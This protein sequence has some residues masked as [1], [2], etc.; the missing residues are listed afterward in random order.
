MTFWDQ[1]LNVYKFRCH[2]KLI[3]YNVPYSKSLVEEVNK[4]MYTE[5]RFMDNFECPSCHF[6]LDGFQGYHALGNM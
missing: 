2:T 3:G 4:T 5:T 6:C 1:R